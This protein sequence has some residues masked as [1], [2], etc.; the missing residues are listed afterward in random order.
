MNQDSPALPTPFTDAYH[1]IPAGMHHPRIKQYLTIKNNTKSNPENLACLEGLWELSLALDQGLPIRAFII[2][3]EQ[4]R[5]DTGRH[6]AKR[7]LD[8]GVHT[9]QVSEKVMERLVDREKPDGLAS[10]VELR[11]FTWDD[12]ILKA[13][14]RIIVLDGLEIP[15]NVGTIV[16]CADG[17]GADAAIITSRR[18]RLSHP[19]VLHSSMGSSISFPVIEAN[20]D[21]AIRWLKAHDFSIITTE[22]DARH[23]YRS[24]DYRKRVAIIVGSERYGIVKEWH[25]AEDERVFIPMAGLVD[26]LNVGNA[27]A[28]M[29]YE[30][31]YQQAPERFIEAESAFGKDTL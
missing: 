11:R 24:I 6:L 12:I 16:R 19:K 5:G 28:I 1:L 2:C 13:T 15:G 29:L 17:T 8:L 25:T 7:I 30:M 31:F 14:N 22:T 10:I 3:P 20:V 4:L 23:S 26:S 27:A 18:T 21:E 9:Y